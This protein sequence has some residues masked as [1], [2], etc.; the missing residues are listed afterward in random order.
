MTNTQYAFL[1]CSIFFTGACLANDKE[2]SF[3]LL[4]ISVS[5]F[6]ITSVVWLLSWI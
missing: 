5:W 2:T 3:L 4:F 6:V 1:L